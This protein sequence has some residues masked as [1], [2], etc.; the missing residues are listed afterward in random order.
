MGE[1]L[2]EIASPPRILHHLFQLR[3]IRSLIFYFRGKRLFFCAQGHSALPE[4]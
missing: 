3:R 1:R 4:G 2:K